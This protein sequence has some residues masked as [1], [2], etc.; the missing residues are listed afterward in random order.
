[1]RRVNWCSA[2][3]NNLAGVLRAQG[4]IAGARGLWERA[5]AIREKMLGW[6][7]PDTASVPTQARQSGCAFTIIFWHVCR[8]R[9]TRCAQLWR[10]LAGK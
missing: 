1:V 7:H 5:L 4:D 8:N 2:S 9:W 6:E 3:L 10:I